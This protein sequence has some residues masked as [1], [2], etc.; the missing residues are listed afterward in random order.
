MKHLARSLVLLV[1]VGNCL[2][3]SG[4][5]PGKQ[6]PSIGVSANVHDFGSTEVQWLLRVWNAGDVGSELVWNASTEC[7]WIA[8]SPSS[9]VSTGFDDV[10][11]VAVTISRQYLSKANYPTTIAV[12][13]EGLPSVLVTVEADDLVVFVDGNNNSGDEDG[14]WWDRAFTSLQAGIDAAVARGATEV[15]VAT[16]AFWE[17]I[18]LKSGISVYGGFAGTETS[19]SERD[20]AANPTVI[21]A[22]TADAGG[23]AEHVVAMNAVTNTL[24]DGFTVTGGQSRNTG[25]SA[26]PW[27]NGGGGIWC[28]QADSTNTIANCTITKNSSPW[29]GGGITCCDSSLTITNC[30]IVENDGGNEGGG[31]LCVGSWTTPTPDSPTFIGCTL[32]GNTASL[33]AGI[34]CYHSAPVLKNCVISGN[35]SAGVDCRYSSYAKFV[36]CLISGNHGPGIDCL[37][38]G[39]PAV[40]NSVISG[41]QGP[42]ITSLGLVSNTACFPTLTNTILTGNDGGV[43]EEH[44]V[45][46][47]A[48][49]VHCL[50]HD[51]GGDYYDLDTLTLYTGANDVNTN[52]TGAVNNV[53]GPAL[54]VEGQK[55][56]W[57]ATPTYDAGTNRTTLVDATATFT[58]GALE[59]RL[60]NPNTGQSFL[61]FVATNSATSM[62]LFGDVTGLAQ[63]GDQYEFVD[64]H[65]QYGSPCIDTGSGADAPSVDFD[66]EARPVDV[67]GLGADGTGA[68]YDIGADEFSP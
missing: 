46:S 19:F 10:D 33:G 38:I 17:S 39:S 26:D 61:G 63:T 51:N 22:S 54:F 56:T 32:A 59:D 31:V 60:I 5:P 18:T 12:S 66:T 8:V 25:S 68:E 55:G 52:V 6:G 44:G 21:D 65:L 3:S 29:S 27:K 13:A 58:P 41:N 48:T 14:S 42:G 4:C 53:D 11:T 20:I 9:G 15:W 45:G 2:L 23:P 24:L 28:Y 50:F 36:N 34:E 47:H 57:T 7:S 35:S 67:P 43:V 62:E 64:Y 37:E 1:A 49:L 30:R 40:V 16:G